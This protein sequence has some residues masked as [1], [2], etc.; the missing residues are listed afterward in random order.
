[1]KAHKFLAHGGVGPFSGRAWP[2]VG[3][4]IETIGELAPCVRGVHVCR[5]EDLAH[6]IHDELWELETDGDHVEGLDCLVVPRA[7]LVRRI[8]AWSDGGARAFAE[9]CVAHAEEQC[10]S[11]ELLG[12]ARIL[13]AEGYVAVAAYTTALAVSRT[14]ND[15]DGDYARERVWQSLWIAE[16]I[17]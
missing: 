13:T 3:E 2:A 17:L 9:A 10:D 1:M 5:A 4:W 8:D 15:P 14:G 16:R 12:D 7:R 6:W 11:S